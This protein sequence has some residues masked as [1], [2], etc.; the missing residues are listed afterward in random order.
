M[1]GLRLWAYIA[2]GAAVV[3]GL[4]LFIHDQRAIGGTAERAK[5]EKANEEFR[6]RVDQSGNDFAS[7]DRAGG[8]YNFR[9]G[10]CE[11]P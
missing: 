5:Q 1:T 10:S 6:K 2:M 11:R 4:A 9:T 7:C 3:G 8:L